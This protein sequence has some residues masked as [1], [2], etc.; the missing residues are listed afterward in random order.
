MYITAGVECFQ[1]KS[2]DGYMQC[3]PQ[4]DLACSH[5][6]DTLFHAKHASIKSDEPIL[7]R[8]PDTDVLVL[9]V[10]ICGEDTGSFPLIFRVLH[11]KAWRYI[12]VP[13][14]SRKLDAHVM[15]A[16][17]CRVCTHLGDVIRQVSLL[18]MER[19]PQ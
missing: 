4:V 1:L 16:K 9:T 11:Q 10:F 14:I 12:S 17:V 18:V 15:C 19:R 8:S 5:E 13:S 6:E 3:V 7:I 2:A